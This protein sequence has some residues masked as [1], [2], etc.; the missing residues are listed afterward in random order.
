VIGLW[1]TIGGALVGGALM[2]RL[3]LWRSLLLFGVLQMA[4]NLG[5]CGWRWP[6]KVPSAARPR[7]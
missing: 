5:F 1:L 4:S 2:L 3:G 6:A 7:C